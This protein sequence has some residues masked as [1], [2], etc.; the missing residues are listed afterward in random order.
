MKNLHHWY[1]II[2][3]MNKKTELHSKVIN[4][5]NPDCNIH[6]IIEFT[7]YFYENHRQSHHKIATLYV[8]TTTRTGFA[9]S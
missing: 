6:F 3:T 8:Q 1:Q 7:F 4:V 9:I 5:Y 2:Y